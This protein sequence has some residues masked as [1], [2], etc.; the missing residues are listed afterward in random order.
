MN[1]ITVALTNG[2]TI[3][4][5]MPAD[6]DF[7]TWIRTV[8]ADGYIIGPKLYIALAAVAGVFVEDAEQKV[9]IQPAGA[10]LQ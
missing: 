7:P 8:R 1:K 5:E 4:F 6:F 9:Q 3:N 10:T 2:A